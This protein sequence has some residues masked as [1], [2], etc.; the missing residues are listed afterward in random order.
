M[1]TFVTV[2]SGIATRWEDTGEM[3]LPLQSCF[4]AYIPSDVNNVTGA[5]TLFALGNST[6]FTEVFDRNSDF[7]TNGTF[8]APVT[9]IYLFNINITMKGI[10]LLMTSAFAQ[11]TTTA[12]SYTGGY[13][14]PFA[15]LA[16]SGL[17]SLSFSVLA[18]MAATNT[19]TF[20]VSISGG[21]G[22]TA[23][24]VGT[25]SPYSTFISGSLIA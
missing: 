8:T 25:G 1:A 24:V 14:N 17:V 23:D 21:A 4:L 3:T 19:A 5:G 13:L 18:D 9:G 20:S 2:P 22:D 12:R 10:S 11:V 7:N 16:G 15:L 6:A